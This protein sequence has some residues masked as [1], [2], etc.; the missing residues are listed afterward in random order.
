M[1]FQANKAAKNGQ[2][3]YPKSG[4][5]FLLFCYGGRKSYLYITTKYLIL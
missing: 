5:K 2:I 4:V 3:D 1:K